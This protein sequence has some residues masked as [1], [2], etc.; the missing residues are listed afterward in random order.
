M[1][2][3]FSRKTVLS[4]WTAYLHC[5]VQ[6]PRRRPRLPPSL[7]RLPAGS[8]AGAHAT[9]SGQGA[10][11]RGPGP[12]TPQEEEEAGGRQ[13]SNCTSGGGRF[14]PD[15]AGQSSV[16]LPV[17]LGGLLAWG[18]QVAEVEVG[19]HVPH[20]QHQPVQAL[21]VVQALGRTVLWPLPLWQ[22]GSSEQGLSWDAG[23]APQLP[24]GPR[25]RV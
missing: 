20:G 9:R 4:D 24:W 7:S 13:V 14:R 10:H 11:A 25:P 16:P 5:P 19:H 3:P 15:R 21:V 8:P 2:P 22:R 6:R 23:P 12:A 18:L 1:L 17:P